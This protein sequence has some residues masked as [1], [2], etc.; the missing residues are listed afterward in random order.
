M[1]N[2]YLLGKASTGKFRYAQVECDEEWHEPEH[3]YIIQRS[4]GQVRGKN[5]LS[6]AIVVDRT[7]QKRNWKEQYTLQFNSEVKKFLDKGYIEV[8]KHPNEYSEEELN[9]L[10]GE[11][12]TNQYGVIKPQLAK[13]ADKVT[14]PKIFDKEWLISRKLDGVKALFYYKDGEIHTAS[15]GGEDYD[16]STT[17]LREDSRL[18]DFFR[19]NPTVILDGEL[20]KRGKTLQQISGAARLEKNAYDCDWLE[21]WIY[22]CYV[23]DRPELDALDRYTILIEQLYMKRNIHV[24]KSIEDDEIC[25]TIHLLDHISVEGWDNMMKLHDQYVNEGFEG[26]CITDPEKP[27]KPGSRGNQ[28]IKIKKYKSEDFKVIGYKLGLRGSEDMTFTCELEDGRTFEAM[29]CGDRATKA[30]Y[31]ENFEEKYKG[32]KAECTFFNYSDDGIPTQPKARI[33]RFDLE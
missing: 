20:F 6:P 16:A 1:L 28:L 31:V 26:A 18:L 9:E 10:F 11:V 24:Y 27:Y 17:H 30:E 3:G 32:H 7:K 25:D 5:T 19:A 15:R 33:F 23:T 22:D 14:N 13:Q 4:Y 12:K 29:P 21:Y 2:K 8:E